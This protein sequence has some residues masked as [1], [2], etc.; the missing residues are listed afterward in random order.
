MRGEVSRGPS[1]LVVALVATAAGLPIGIV[2]A[3]W[4]GLDGWGNYR[5]G[6]HLGR[7]LAEAWV[8]MLVLAVGGLVLGALVGR[9]GWL[10]G[11]VAWPVVALGVPSLVGVSGAG[12]A[13]AAILIAAGSI[14]VATLGGLAGVS[15][16]A[17]GWPKTA[18]LLAAVLIAVAVLHAAG[19]WLTGL[20]GT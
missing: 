3:A 11:I 9:H 13:I 2:A 7:L 19:G 10:A 15:L 18:G 1:H 6:Y 12:A 8:T 5:D 16:R 17:R 14:G 20:P 4:I